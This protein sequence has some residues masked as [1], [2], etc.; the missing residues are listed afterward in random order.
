[1]SFR[2]GVVG[3]VRGQFAKLRLPRGKH[4]EKSCSTTSS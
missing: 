2:D 4:L 1:M 3:V